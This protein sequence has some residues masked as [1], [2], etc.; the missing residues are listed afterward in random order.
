VR[1]GQGSKASGWYFGL[2]ASPGF[3]GRLDRIHD[4]AQLIP[5]RSADVRGGFN[6]RQFSF[7]RKPTDMV[8][9]ARSGVSV[10]PNFR[11]I[12]RPRAPSGLLA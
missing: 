5:R 12:F 11:R 4:Y 3:G 8:F 7:L 6:S 10:S 1:A 9:M 2:I